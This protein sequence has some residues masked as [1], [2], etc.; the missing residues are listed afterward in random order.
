[1]QSQEIIGSHPWYAVQVRPRYERIVASTLLDKG[2]E[3]FLP[4]CRCRR[5]WSDRIKELEMP[6]FSGYLFC[7][8]DISRRLPVLRTPGVIRFVGIGKTPMPVDAQEI[9]AIISIVSA[10]MNMVPHPY[11]QVGQR[12]RIECG[13]LAGVEGIVLLAKKPA[14]LVVSVSLLQRSVAVEIDESWLTPLSPAQSMERMLSL[15]PRLQ[16]FYN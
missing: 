13:T 14:R 12:V 8:L 4:M 2:Y 7:R 3:G 16:K 9:S 15:A 1:M 11:L 5:R 6:L 10:Q